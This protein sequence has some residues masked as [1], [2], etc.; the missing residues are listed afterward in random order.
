M[1]KESSPSCAKYYST[2]L[3]LKLAARTRVVLS[4]LKRD[5]DPKRREVTFKRAPNTPNER[6]GYWVSKENEY[7]EE[8]DFF[9]FTPPTIPTRSSSLRRKTSCYLCKLKYK[10]NFRSNTHSCTSPHTQEASAQ[11]TQSARQ[12]YLPITRSQPPNPPV[13]SSSLPLYIQLQKLALRGANPS[14]P[15]SHMRLSGKERLGVQW[16]VLEYCS[17]SQD[18][19]EFTGFRNPAWD[20]ILKM[21]YV[22][23][24]LQHGV[25]AVVA[26]L[27]IHG[28]VTRSKASRSRP[29]DGVLRILT[30]NK[31]AYQFLRYHCHLIGS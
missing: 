18:E 2:K 17:K 13:R 21:C 6:A 30:R 31:L 16:L 29:V 20:I 1:G 27:R 5:G 10:D 12:T 3:L 24:R 19:Y 14:R 15:L 7:C 11:E 8:K 25:L 28:Q 22:D 4:A 9:S 23:P 26:A